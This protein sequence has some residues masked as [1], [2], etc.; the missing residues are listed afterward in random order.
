MGTDEGG[1]PPVRLE[2][3]VR[4]LILSVQTDVPYHWYSVVVE[5]ASSGQD[6]V[7]KHDA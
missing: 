6:R 2:C 1:R 4:A 3:N 5:V 7:T